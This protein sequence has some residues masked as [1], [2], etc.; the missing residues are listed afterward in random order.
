M[1]N[2]EK[3]ELPEMEQIE[4]PSNVISQ[5]VW[6]NLDWYNSLLNNI[7][8]LNDK[9]EIVPFEVKLAKL[10]EVPHNKIL[11]ILKP[12]NDEKYSQPLVA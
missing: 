7:L 9:D 12:A 4:I 6:K 11:K 10:L 1:K 5:E 2:N 3:F 8:E